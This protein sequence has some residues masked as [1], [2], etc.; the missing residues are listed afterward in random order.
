MWALGSFTLLEGFTKLTN[1]NFKDRNTDMCL[2]DHSQNPTG[3]LSCFCS[4]NHNAG[5][6]RLYSFTTHTLTRVQKCPLPTFLLSAL[7][8]VY[9]FFGEIFRRCEVRDGVSFTFLFSVFG[10]LYCL[11]FLFLQWRV[12]ALLPFPRRWLGSFLPAL[13]VC[14]S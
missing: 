12:W 14:G 10:V 4:G 11:H 1:A 7:S 3:H 6:H 8:V 13:S 2:Q 5:V 9:V